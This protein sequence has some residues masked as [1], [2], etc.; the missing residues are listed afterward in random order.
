VRASDFDSPAARQPL[1]GSSVATID[2]CEQALRQLAG[3]LADADPAARKKA[4]FD[5]TLVCTL[6]D[7]RVSFAG[8]L[9]DGTLTDIRQVD[10][11]ERGAQVRMTMTSTDLLAL[12]AGELN[13]GAA[14]ATGRVKIDASVFDLLKLRAVF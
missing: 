11:G 1:E 10:A 3:Q 7:L 2:D 5:R 13:L 8:R 9:H 4:G 14:W 12:V 6:R